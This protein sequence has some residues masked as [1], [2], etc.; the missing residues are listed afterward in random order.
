MTHPRDIRKPG[1]INSAKQPCERAVSRW[2]K[3]LMRRGTHAAPSDCDRKNQRKRRRRFVERRLGARYLTGDD[4]HA[5]RESIM[6]H[7]F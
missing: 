4:I 5:L 6:N 3:W 1:T 2:R 7:D